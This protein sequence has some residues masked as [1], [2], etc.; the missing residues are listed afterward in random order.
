MKVNGWTKAKHHFSWDT[1][2]LLHLPPTKWTGELSVHSP[3][4]PSSWADSL[5]FI[6]P[7]VSHHKLVA[8]SCMLAIISS[9]WMFFLPLSCYAISISV[10]SANCTS[11]FVGP[12]ADWSIG[13]FERSMIPL[14]H[15]YTLW[16]AS[17]ANYWS[18]LLFH[19][20]Q[21]LLHTLSVITSV[22]FVVF[23][24]K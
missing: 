21:K 16:F 5:S 3:S 9:R 18:H 19:R 14:T 20:P 23:I 1:K 6:H 7:P 12:S 10:Q 4:R 15:T 24:M 11:K 2:L 13:I 8:F 17:I 22:S